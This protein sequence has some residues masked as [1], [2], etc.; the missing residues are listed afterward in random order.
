MPGSECDTRIATFDGVGTTAITVDSQS[1]EGD[2]SS[3]KTETLSYTISPSS[4]GKLTL[5]PI[6]AGDGGV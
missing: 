1:E 4:T 6:P 3:G 2:E 5:T